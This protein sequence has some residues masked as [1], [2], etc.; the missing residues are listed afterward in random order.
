MEHQVGQIGAGQW[1]AAGELHLHD[2]RFT[3][4][5]EHVAP[6]LG[7]QL[8]RTRDEFERAGTVRAVPGGSGG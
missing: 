8:G 6:L 4:L 5:R 2:A 1:P 3:S 7:S